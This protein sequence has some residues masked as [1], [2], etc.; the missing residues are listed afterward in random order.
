ME[1]VALGWALMGT[2]LVL[3]AIALLLKAR[4]WWTT[5][6]LP[7]EEVIYTDTG[8][9]YPQPEPLFAP[10]LGL[11]GRPDY[12][13]READGKIIPVEVKGTLAPPEPYLGHVLQLGAYCLLVAAAYGDTPGY[14][15]IQYQDRAFAVPFTPQLE[16]DLR[17]LLDQMRSDAL[18]TNVDRDHR[19]QARC[20]G[21]GHR[22][23]CHQRLA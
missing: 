1:T 16:G 6:G 23:H 9:W 8:I 14:G 5:S 21:C 15:I 18:E 7:A 10:E 11:T 3:L 2:S 20:A 22:D 13:V 4:Q 12:L 17:L 19:S